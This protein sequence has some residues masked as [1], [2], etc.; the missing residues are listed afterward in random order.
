[1]TQEEIITKAVLDAIK[2]KQGTNINMKMEPAEKKMTLKMAKELIEKIEAK[3]IEWGMRIVAAVSD[4]SGRIIAV[5]CMDGAYYG[6]YDVAVNKCFTSTAF[7]MPTS[8]LSEL[9]KPGGELYGLQFSNDGKVMILG[10]G[11][12]LYASGK[13]IGALGVSGS[14]VEKDTA[15][16]EYGFRIFEEI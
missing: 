11:V 12:P 2:E 8:K 10:G 7:Q 13:L 5:H 3:A 4:E 14:T 1:M 9:C 15:L 6:S 16:A